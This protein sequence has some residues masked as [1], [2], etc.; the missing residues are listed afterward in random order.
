MCGGVVCDWAENSVGY[1][2]SP[3]YNNSKE[4]SYNVTAKFSRGGFRFQ[5]INWQYLQGE[6]HFGN[7]TQWID[8]K[9]RGL[10][11]KK[12][13]A[14]NNFRRLGILN[15]LLIN[16]EAGFSGANWDVRNNTI[17]TGYLAELSDTLS[18]DSEVVVRHTQILNSSKDSYQNTLGPG[19][20]YQ[21]GIGF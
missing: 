17:M 6:G 16:G 4:D 12:F 15:G 2:S 18:I 11:T 8:A 13:D 5:T 21:P 9:E 7:G 3:F 10:E 14:R 1:Y 19:A 20:Y